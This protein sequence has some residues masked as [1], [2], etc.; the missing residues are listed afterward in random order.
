MSDL[1]DAYGHVALPRFLSGAEFLRVMDD[2]GVGKALVCTAETCPDLAELS[3]T[4]CAWPDRFL[5]AGLPLGATPQERHDGVR[6]QMASGFCGIRI[7]ESR[8]RD[9]PALGDA[10]G[11]AGGLL[12]V[13]GSDGL[14]SSA[15]ALTNW[16]V[17]YPGGTVLAPHFASGG[18]PALFKTHPDL[19]RLYAH[20][21]FAVIASRQG[22][23]VRDRLL[24]WLTA[25]YD[26]VGPGRLLW[27]SEYPVAL[28]RNESYADTIRWI[29]SAMPL[30][31]DAGFRRD[32]ADRLI[33]GRRLVPTPLDARWCRMDLAAPAPVWLFP[34]HTLDV[35]E[36]A[37]RRL[38]EAYL[39]AGGDRTEPYRDFVARVLA[40]DA[41][42]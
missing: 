3:R 39:R 38:L 23:F 13:V 36:T 10:V 32:N 11:A 40:T 37:N 30:N 31:D 6:A 20:P 14:T 15:T 18:D 27:G 28:Y 41:S 33:F 8:L 2:H 42:R 35:P 34:N 12:L 24:P 7:P 9:E 22:M 25:V 21:R 4:A 29:E 26:R 16:L 19:E 1:R 5:V 17:K